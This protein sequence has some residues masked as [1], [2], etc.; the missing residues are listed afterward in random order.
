MNL[1]ESEC[2]IWSLYIYITI[3]RQVFRFVK[4]ISVYY[5]ACVPQICLPPLITSVP[6]LTITVHAEIKNSVI[7]SYHKLTY[8][9]KQSCV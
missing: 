6:S 2:I 7:I 9:E 1:A 8:K 5:D 3:L 4:V